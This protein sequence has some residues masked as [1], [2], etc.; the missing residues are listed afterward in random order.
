VGLPVPAPILTR[1]DWP[2]Q[3]GKPPWETQKITS[4]LLTESPRAYV[5]STMGTGKTA[6]ARSG[7]RIT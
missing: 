6:A 3:P 2:H 7:Q 1:Y 5:L 4:A